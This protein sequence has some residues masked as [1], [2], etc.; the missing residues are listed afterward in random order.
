MDTHQTLRVKKSSSPKKVAGA[1][2]ALVRG[3]AAVALDAIGAGAVNQALKAVAIARGYVAPSGRELYC[4]PAFTKIA[5]NGEE[6]TGL[7]LYVIVRSSVSSALP[8]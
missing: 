6:R 1:L 7:R 3:G 2:A 4:L 5:V 8:G